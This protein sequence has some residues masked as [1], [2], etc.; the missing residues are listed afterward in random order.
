MDGQLIGAR[1]VLALEID[2]ALARWQASP[3]RWGRDDCALALAEIYRRALG[4]DPAAPLRGRYRTERGARRL[5]GRRGMLGTVALAA[6]R[7]SWRRIA[8]AAAAPGDL[9]LVLT[10]AGPAC[11]IRG[12]GHWL[13]RIDYGFSAHPDQAI[14]RAWSVA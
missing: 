5:V 6:R 7:M 9:G 13:N 4:K 3:M 8:P 10:D 12:R 11:V 1:D 14:A 2:A